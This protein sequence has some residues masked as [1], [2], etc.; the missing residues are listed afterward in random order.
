MLIRYTQKGKLDMRSS[1][2]NPGMSE[3]PAMFVLAQALFVARCFSECINVIQQCISSQY[4]SRWGHSPS[5]HL[6]YLKLKEYAERALRHEERYLL[7][8]DTWTDYD[9]QERL[10]M[11]R[12][13]EIKIV[14]YPWLPE[15]LFRRSEGDVIRANNTL[16]ALSQDSLIIKKSRLCDTLRSCG[17]I[18][19]D[20]DAYGV[21]ARTD[22]PAKTKLF[23][24]KTILCATNGLYRCT[25][26]CADL[27]RGARRYLGKLYCDRNCFRSLRAACGLGTLYRYDQ[28]RRETIPRPNGIQLPFPD[29]D[30]GAAGK[31]ERFLFQR[32]L[33][34][35]HRSTQRY[36]DRHPLQARLLSN[37]TARYHDGAGALKAFSYAEDV[38]DRLGFLQKLGVDIFEDELA[39]AW[40]LETL[41]NRLQNNTREYRGDNGDDV[42]AVNTT[43]SFLNHS[44]LP[45]VKINCLEDES[46][47]ICVTTTRRIERGEELF[48]SYLT[49][50]DLQESHDVR[51]EKLR[52]WTGGMCLCA[53]CSR[54]RRRAE[55]PV[56]FLRR[57]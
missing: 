19:H 26:C 12:K 15:T 1:Q 7:Q 35:A 36:P 17:Q 56:P 9:E 47:A 14:A 34:V 51:E 48:V 46:S 22:I 10:E 18:Q 2:N 52:P 13:G 16:Q 27:N 11:M 37:L 5:K 4:R 50:E 44:C 42:V 29:H 43:Y 3:G 28:D 23:L 55:R 31:E 54:E 40:I 57:G 49:K 21:F 24:D 32:A 38:C 30:L 8:D 41:S 6:N 33:K 45:N 25:T 39:E 53:K 20:Q